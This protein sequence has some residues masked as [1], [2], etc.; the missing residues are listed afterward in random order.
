[1]PLAG[2]KVPDTRL[3]R[4]AIDLARSSSEPFLFNHVMRS[5]LFSVLLSENAK[6]APDP[7]L[8]AVSTVLHDLGL[9]DRFSAKERFEVDGANAALA[10]MKERGISMQQTQVVWDAI[11][12]HTTRSIALHK[13]AEVAMTHSGI[14]VD[15]LG[16]GL[17]RIHQDKQQAILAAFPRLALKSQFQSSLCNIVRR[18]PAT[19]FDNI[20]RDFGTRYVDGFTPPNFA[21][22]VANSP[23]SE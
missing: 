20:L 11:A 19:S 1:M 15:V 9:T 8:L 10:F 23:F 22:L 2:I 5:W 3:V 18:K 6:P 13:E 12:L 4:D 17:D 21:D 16:V 7:E 14:A